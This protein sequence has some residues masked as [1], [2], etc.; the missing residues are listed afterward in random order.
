MNDNLILYGGGALIIALIIWKGKTGL[1]KLV[2]D[3]HGNSIKLGDKIKNTRS[4]MNTAYAQ[5]DVS[6]YLK[7]E[8]ELANLLAAAEIA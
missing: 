7:F 8:Q 3:G 6:N 4:Y 5:N 1:N 2:T